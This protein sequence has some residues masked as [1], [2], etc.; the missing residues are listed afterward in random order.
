MKPSLC[1]IVPGR[2]RA[3][4]SHI[5]SVPWLSTACSEEAASAN[6]SAPSDSST[7]C[8]RWCRP[9]GLMP[10]ILRYVLHARRRTAS[11]AEMASLVVNCISLYHARQGTWIAPC[12]WTAFT[13]VPT[14]TLK[15]LPV[16]PGQNWSATSSAPVLVVSANALIS[17]HLSWFWFSVL[18]PTLQAW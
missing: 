10:V 17:L 5:S 6:M 1:G 14:I 11:V 13:P 7:L 18:L 4:R 9:W 12:A 8:I 16:C 2:R 3:W 15:S